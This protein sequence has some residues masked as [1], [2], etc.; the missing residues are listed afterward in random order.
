[1]TSIDAST[2]PVT[3]QPHQAAGEYAGRIKYDED[4][5]RR[6]QVRKERR[7]RAEMR[8]IDRAFK[9][10]PKKHIVLDVPCGGGRA[11]EHLARQGYAV[12]AADLSDAMLSI[13][14]EKLGQKKMIL[15]VEK[16]DV[17]ALSFPSRAFDTILCFRLFHH[18]PT[19]DIRRRVVAE[20]CR[21][22]R[23]YVVL[24]YFSPFSATSLKRSLRLRFG[25]KPSQKHATP[26]SEVS[27]YFE[28]C[29]FHLVKDF[30][31]LPLV[32][33]MHLALFAR[34]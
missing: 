6:Y 17:E 32:H 14:R 18:F 28:Q 3:L 1:M 19:E 7:H 24:S 29:G 23:E 34:T 25:G 22:A 26:L 13:A 27:G 4:T 20:L 12:G 31:Q 11:A 30:A 16:Q 5:A 21:V 15:F 2:T 10:I 8:L 9:N 33:T